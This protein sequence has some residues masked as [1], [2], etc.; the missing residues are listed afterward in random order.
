VLNTA[1]KYVLIYDEYSICR[2]N[3]ANNTG[4]ESTMPV[5]CIPHNTDFFFLSFH[6]TYII[7]SKIFLF[8][9]CQSSLQ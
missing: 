6:I 5:F 3:L 2:D 7:V 9:V 1:E 4:E 8:F